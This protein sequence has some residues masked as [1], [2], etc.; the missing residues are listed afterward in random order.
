MKTRLQNNLAGRRFG[1]L[2]V[3]GRA[4]DVGKGK[5][6][7]VK[8]ECLCD[9]GNHTVVKSDSLLSGHTSS[10]GC[11]KVKHGYSHKE[12]LYET[13]KNM[14]R[15]CN[16]PKNKRWANYG[17]KGIKVCPEGDDYKA[18]REWALS[19]GY[20]D[21]M[22]IDRIDND[23]GYCPENCRWTDAKT[24]ANNQT[25]NRILKYQGKDYTMA[26]LADE[27]GITYPALHHRVERGR[28]PDGVL[29]P[30]QIDEST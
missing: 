13:W 10:C 11:Q 21:S 23:V 18:F 28:L 17:G 29:D 9:C 19:N 14:R 1:T 24:Q 16:D 27:L 15:R 22:T 20:N 2:Q 5:K 8:W 3:M 7:V 26:Q 6:P 12:R 25:R 4:D 30:N